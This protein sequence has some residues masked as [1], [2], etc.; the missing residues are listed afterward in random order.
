MLR[1]PTSSLKIIPYEVWLGVKPDISN[2]RVLGSVVYNIRPLTGHK[3]PKLQDKADKGILLGFEGEHIYRILLDNGKGV[4]ESN[5][6]IVESEPKLF[7]PETLMVQSGPNTDPGGKRATESMFKPNPKKQRIAIEIL[8]PA[9]YKLSTPR[10]S[11]F[12]D[13]FIYLTAT[14]RLTT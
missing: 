13:G 10:T 12:H 11:N 3:L 4:R 5:V 2:I 9:H 7:K 8:V 1:S 6:H 14:M